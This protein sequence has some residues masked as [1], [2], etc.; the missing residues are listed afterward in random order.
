LMNRTRSRPL[1]S[2]R[3]SP[4]SALAFGMSLT[5][6]AEI[7]LALYV[8]PLTA[9][10]GVLV[11][12]GY[13]VLYTPL[14]TRTSL[15]TVVGAIPGA[16]PP[17][18]GWTAVNNR[19]SIGAI[20][21]FAIMFLWQFPHFLAIAWMYREDYERAGILMLPVVEPDG[22]ITARQIMLYS[23]LL[24]PTSLVPT[25]IGLSGRVYFFGAIMLGLL[26][27]FFAAKTAVTM[28]KPSA[29]RLLLASVLYLPLLFVLMVLSQ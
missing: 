15:S 1:P 16:M 21:L 5:L 26:L 14:K 20:A 29:R 7:F 11:V 13:L 19:I 28:T 25:L 18:L 23:L 4:G 9:G 27:I 12:V 17:L 2:K 10:L 6:I 3:L 24:L 8:N 22:R